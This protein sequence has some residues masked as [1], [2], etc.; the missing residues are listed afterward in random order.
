MAEDIKNMNKINNDIRVLHSIM[1][2]KII[3]LSE[4]N[5]INQQGNDCARLSV[6]TLIDN[7]FIKNKE[8]GD[9]IDI[10]YKTTS[11]E[12][13]LSNTDNS[14]SSEKIKGVNHG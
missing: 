13:N 14:C 8:L 4:T 11:D 7:L 9:Y 5:N 2:E 6:N 12:Y 1:L 10:L 3:E